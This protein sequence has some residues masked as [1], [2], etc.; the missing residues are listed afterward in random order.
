MVN[1]EIASTT[2]TMLISIKESIFDLF[3]SN[4]DTLGIMLGL[5]VVVMLLV[6]FLPKI[7]NDKDLY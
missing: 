1:S 7:F 2:T 3:I 6:M 4:V 5:F